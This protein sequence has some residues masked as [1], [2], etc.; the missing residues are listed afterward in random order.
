MRA[1]IALLGA[2]A[3]LLLSLGAGTAQADHRERDR[4][5]FNRISKAEHKL[6]E[7]IRKHGWRSRQAEKRR[8][9]LRSTQSRCGGFGWNRGRDDNV[10][11]RD[12]GRDDWRDDDRRW[13]RGRDDNYWNRGRNRDR[14]NRNRH[15]P[16][17]WFWSSNGRRHRHSRNGSWCHDRH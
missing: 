3:G 14:W 8:D 15:R 4:Q 7:A 2:A 11:G 10:W 9:E 6:N 16:V 5:C 13:N 17:S 12:R 1:R